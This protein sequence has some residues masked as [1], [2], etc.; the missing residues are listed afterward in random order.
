MR[1]MT[2]LPMDDLNKVGPAAREIEAAGY[3]GAMTMEHA[4]PP[5]SAPGDRGGGDQARGASDRR[6]HRLP[7]KPHGVCVRRVGLAGR[8]ER[9]LRPGARLAG[10]RAQR[11]AFQRALERARRA[12]ARIRGIAARVMA[13]LAE[14][15]KTR[16]PRA[17][18]TGSAS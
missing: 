8:L 17:N 2:D 12:H 13:R 11:A 5:V 16:L 14:R 10:P 4:S 3:D 6:G 1:I 9:T 15:G 18:T 7:Q